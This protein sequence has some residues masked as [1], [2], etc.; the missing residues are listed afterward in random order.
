MEK[1]LGNDKINS[2][3]TKNC[4]APSLMLLNFSLSRS[5]ILIHSTLKK[6]RGAGTQ[7]LSKTLGLLRGNGV[8]WQL[9]DQSNFS[10]SAIQASACA[11][12]L[13]LVNKHQHAILFGMT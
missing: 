6:I 10:T 13:C 4:S 2:T 1:S 7:P 12:Y 5:D 8:A 11:F 3:K 9:S